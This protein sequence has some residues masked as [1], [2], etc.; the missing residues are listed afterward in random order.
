MKINLFYLCFLRNFIFCIIF[1][2]GSKNYEKK[3][4]NTC[5]LK[6]LSPQ[7]INDAGSV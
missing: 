3:P 5:T 6:D 4:D 2:V 1:S 7:P